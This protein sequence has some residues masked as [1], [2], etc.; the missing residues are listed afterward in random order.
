LPLISA[1]LELPVT[2]GPSH[3]PDT[4]IRV[5]ALTL[6]SGLCG[7]IGAGESKCVAIITPHLRP[8]TAVN[9]GMEKKIKLRDN[10]FNPFHFRF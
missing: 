9:C 10:K 8:A 3:Y 4:L 6:Q 7:E 1:R 5:T 2:A